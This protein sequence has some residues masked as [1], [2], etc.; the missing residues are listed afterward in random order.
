MKSPLDINNLMTLAKERDANSL[1]ASAIANAIVF[2]GFKALDMS[3][4]VQP[5]RFRLETERAKLLSLHPNYVVNTPLI[6]VGSRNT[7]SA[8]PIV[9]TVNDDVQINPDALALLSELA[10]ILEDNQFGPTRVVNPSSEKLAT[11]FGMQLPDEAFVIYA[12]SQPISVPESEKLDFIQFFSKRLEKEIKRLA[13]SK[14]EALVALNLSSRD[15]TTPTKSSNTWRNV[16]IAAGIGVGL[17][18]VYLL[19]KSPKQSL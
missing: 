18:A 9:S 12:K 5:L 10:F 19:V 11:S 4:D 3:V 1:L 6:I 8:T 15:R 7:T 13:S 14:Q 17:L 2:G 16:G